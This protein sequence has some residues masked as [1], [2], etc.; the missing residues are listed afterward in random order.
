MH[1]SAMNNCASFLQT[2]LQ[3]VPTHGKPRVIEIGAADVNGSLR[4]LAPPDVDY[5]GADFVRG[6]GVDVVVDDPY[7]LPFED[8]SADI[9]LSSSCFEHS[10]LFWLVFLEILRILKPTGLFYLNA[11]SNGVFHRYPVDCWR[12]YPDSG[13]ALVTWAKRNQINATV[14][15]GW[16]S[17]ADRL[18]E[19]T[20]R[21]LD[22]ALRPSTASHPAPRSESTL[23]QPCLPKS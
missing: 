6:K 3:H 2:Y 22:E 17:H 13:R 20:R 7:S 5:I 12:F 14:L 9:V 10:E 16:N 23:R 11:P 18:P 15:G 1:A 8:A 4:S 19:A 21:G